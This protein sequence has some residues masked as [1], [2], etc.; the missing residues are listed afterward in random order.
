MENKSAEKKPENKNKE[1]KA[2]RSN[3]FFTISC[4]V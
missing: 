4:G 2:G 1:K 3:I